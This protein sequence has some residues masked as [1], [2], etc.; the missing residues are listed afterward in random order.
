M[1]CL[2]APAQRFPDGGNHTALNRNGIARNA[3][4]RCCTMTASAELGCD[5]IHV[6]PA[7]FRAQAD[8]HES[9]FEFLKGARHDYWF[10]VA[11]MFNQAF[12]VAALSPCARKV[13]LLEPEVSD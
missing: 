2:T 8:T 7:V 12:G 13:L 10:D 4:T 11:D 6:Y 9:R 5:L 1:E 3:R